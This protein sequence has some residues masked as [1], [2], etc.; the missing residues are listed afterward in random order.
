MRLLVAAWL[1]TLPLNADGGD[2]PE[3][4]LERHGLKFVS[5]LWHATS[6]LQIAD[7]VQ[8]AERLERRLYDLSKQID[9]SLEQNELAKT[10]LAELIATQ[11]RLREAR[12][13][14]KG[15][16]AEQ[17]RLD[18][19]IKRQTAVI[20]QL[21]K[22]IV[23]VENLGSAMPLKSALIDLAGVRAE[24]AFHTMA[25][26]RQIE[27]LPA[28]YEGLRNNS[29][30]TAALRAVQ[31][32]GQL[33]PVRA[34]A[35]ELRSL[36]RIEK[37]IFADELPFYRE[38]KRIRITAIANEELPIPFSFYDSN[39]PAVITHTMAESLGIDLDGKPNRRVRL[40]GQYDVRAAQAQLASLRF[41]RHV[42]R[43][44][45][46]LVLPPEN[47]NLGARI[48]IS[49]LRGLRA[50]IVPERLQIR[51][52]PSSEKSEKRAG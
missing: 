25:A 14:L 9:L 26:R 39:E 23:P 27:Q 6:D 8:T 52:E 24:L 40:D 28:V 2:S 50:R 47:E 51:F 3:Q 44:L 32:A 15:G 11:R 16:S 45:N 41:G 29:A 36:G 18:E 12:S 46:V 1:A 49:A 48:G 22:S 17:K 33:A 31:P 34:Y 21:K 30:V 38:G 35:N 4:F 7:R 43:N 10:Q 37:L 20:E 19:Q 5:G 42:V 13:G